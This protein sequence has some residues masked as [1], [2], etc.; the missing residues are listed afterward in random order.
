MKI[1]QL[2]YTTQKL[3]NFVTTSSTHLVNKSSISTKHFNK[4]C[5]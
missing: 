4:K 3:I 5:S 2:L 1:P